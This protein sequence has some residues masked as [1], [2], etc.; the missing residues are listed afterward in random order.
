MS[1]VARGEAPEKG[2]VHWPSRPD[3]PH[4]ETEGVDRESLVVNH[5]EGACVGY[6]DIL[7]GEVA[8]SKAAPATRRRGRKR[9]LAKVL[10]NA[11]A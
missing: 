2:H 1:A 10:P 8:V 6:H 5:Y 4:I 7:G 3:P 11:F 9:I